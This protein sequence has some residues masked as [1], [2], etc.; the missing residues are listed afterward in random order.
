M[1]F[2]GTHDADQTAEPPEIEALLPWY[3]AGTLPRRDRQR[4]EDALRHDPGLARHVELVREELTE[5]ICLN[6]S[7]RAPSAQALDRLMMAIDEETLAPPKADFTRALVSRLA[8]FVAGFSPR[9]L[10]AAG[11]VA[12]LV[13]GVQAFILASVLTNPSTTYRMASV[14]SAPSGPGSFA[15]VRFARDASAA[16]ITQF[17]QNYQATLV[18][19]PKPGG[20]YRVKLAVTKLAHDEFTR[21]VSHM[22]Q[23]R[24]VASAEPTE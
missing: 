4:V 3:A 1:T 23:D 11:A 12:A 19:G 15:M 18:D 16:D 7:L 8:N 22:R 5:T 24:I 6:E 21:I 14:A 13:I 2:D 10:A 9:T 17:L 20:L